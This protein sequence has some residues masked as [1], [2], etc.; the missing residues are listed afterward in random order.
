M[1]GLRTGFFIGFL[2]GALLASL[3]GEMD[4]SAGQ[5]RG[6][7]GKVRSHFTQA[8]L[9]AREAAAAKEEQMRREFDTAT[10]SHR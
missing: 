5:K 10:R 3:R 7:V 6:V 9:A 8:M 2:G 1:T 4:D